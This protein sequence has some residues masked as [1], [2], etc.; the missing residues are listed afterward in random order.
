MAWC[1][2]ARHQAITYANF[3]P[4]LCHHMASLGHSELKHTINQFQDNEHQEKKCLNMNDNFYTS[5]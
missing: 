4:D 2:A 3:Y 5:F 1:L